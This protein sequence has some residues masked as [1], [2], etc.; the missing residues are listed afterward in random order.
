MARPPEMQT[1]VGKASRGDLRLRYLFARSH[2]S[3]LRKQLLLEQGV[4][5][6]PRGMLDASAVTM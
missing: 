3:A 4:D 5:A 6:L 2:E 1:A